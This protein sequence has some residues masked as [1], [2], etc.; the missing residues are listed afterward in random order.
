MVSLFLVTSFLPPALH[1]TIGFRAFFKAARQSPEKE[2]QV[3]QRLK[4]SPTLLIYLLVNK[5]ITYEKDDVIGGIWADSVY[6]PFAE[7]KKRPGTGGG[8]RLL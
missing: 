2:D 7:I 6:G 1:L 3:S 8:K 5:I 4:K